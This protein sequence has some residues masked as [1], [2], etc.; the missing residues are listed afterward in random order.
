[1][2]GNAETTAFARHRF[3]YEG[4]FSRNLGW[5]T[6]WEQQALRAKRVAI[7]GM[8]GVGGVHLTTLARMGIGAFHIADLDNFELANFNRQVGATMATLGAPKA[9]V[10][11][12]MAR[13]IN[14]EVTVAT[15]GDGLTAGNLEAFLAG[16]D[17][18]IDG[19]DF[20][21]IDIRRRVFAR[22]REL[23]IP[24]ITAAPLGMGAA[25]LV[26]EPS[27]MSF[28]Q[29]FGF[30]GLPP[31]RQY[32]RFLVG[33]APR[34]L[35]F[36]YLA[37]RSYVD[38]AGHRGPSTASAV[39]L[40]AGAAAAEAVKLLLRRGRVRAAP[41]FHQFDAYRGKWVSG[42]LRLG[43][44]H[45][46]QRLKLALADRA[47]AAMSRQAATPAPT[48]PATDLE[49]IVDAARWAPSGD[50]TQ[51]WR[52]R[53]VGVDRLAIDLSAQ[54]ATDVYDYR[55]G[56][57][58]MLSAGM[59]LES[60][61]IS[62]SSLGR[63]M[64]WSY[65]GS[66]GNIHHISV[67]LP[68]AEGHA[69]DRLLSSL[70]L[71]SVDRRPYPLDRLADVQREALAAAL[72]GTLEIE[73]HESLASRWRFARLSALAT[74]IRLR[75]LEAFRVH[76][77]VVDWDRAY[78]PTGIPAGALG[79][80]P[81]TL[82][83][84]RWA[85]QDWRRLQRMNRWPGATAAATVELDYLPALCCAGFF[86]LRLPAPRPRDKAARMESL[87]KAGSA[88]QRFWLTATQLGLALQP[89]LAIL[90]FAHYGR[91]GTA[92]T[93]D[94]ALRSKAQALQRALTLSIGARA[95][96]LV[97]LG[98]VGRRPARPPK[99]RS[100]RLRIA[101]LMRPAVSDEESVAT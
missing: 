77:R 67:H 14:P 3:S 30:D 50:N 70:F 89:S 31:E 35:H 98:R 7:A 87:L 63:A 61:R 101:D 27:G 10:L 39:Q 40:C 36:R 73:W 9:D 42:R 21:A 22:C 68:K 96:D 78:S 86:S 66:S 76:Q 32:V 5:L 15:F 20:F 56:E 79:L 91:D 24:A 55:D 6:E 69:P 100:V 97:F 65:D 48:R 8:G 47:F 34:A 2:D 59:L 44:R 16:V 99:A 37:D 72:G 11:A 13:D 90:I 33:L 74:D 51:P 71:R 12:A 85:M 75:C 83:T 46:L 95:D 38:L 52:I 64:D 41:H 53:P 29:Y 88:I 60:I 80:D 54:A 43:H 81:A 92:F 57:P 1:M 62:A 49:R 18:F 94:K 28:E 82:K 19:L 45:P 17:L 26:F 58:T 93:E 84:M 25:Y 4:A 23:G